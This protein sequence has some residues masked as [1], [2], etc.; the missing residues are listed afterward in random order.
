MVN[1]YSKT[2]LFS[3]CVN[4]VNKCN[5]LEPMF[6]LS[7]KR[8]TNKEWGKV[9]NNLAVLDWNQKYQYEGE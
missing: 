2:T 3:E 6:S 8:D 9:M 7:E 4:R 5:F 1:K